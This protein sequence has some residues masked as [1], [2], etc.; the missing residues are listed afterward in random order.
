MSA[1]VE[2]LDSQESIAAIDRSGMLSV[3]GEMPAMMEKAERIAA[4]V[5]LPK[6]DQVSQVLVLGMGGSAISGDIAS[7]ILF[8]RIKVPLLVNRGYHIPEFV[9]PETLILALSYSG[10][11]EEV[12]NATREAERKQARIICVTSGGKLQ[13]MA[14]S[15]N[16]PLFQIPSGYQPRAALP[17]MLVPLLI[18][19]EKTGMIGDVSAE[20]KEARTLLQK[21]SAEYGPRKPQRNNAVKQLAK[22]LLNKTPI[23]FGSAYSTGAAA[24][25]IKDQF[26]ENSKVTAIVDYFPEL[27]HNQIASLSALKREE[28]EFAWIILRDEGDSERVKKVIEIVKSLIGQK[29][30][31]VNE[32]F[33]EGKS[34]LARILSLIIYGDYLSVYLALLRGVDPT[35]V[36]AIGRLKK[37]MQ[38]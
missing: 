24:L 33:S 23:I 35:P 38:R 37:E 9:G 30:G 7:D 15:K 10:D 14:A 6:P 20:I 12:L 28:N 31:G 36:E 5:S 29:L 11:T 21:L 32:L 2:I 18:G 26:N 8:K 17:F 4:A 34:A 25:R 16:Y 3:V 22:K 13:Q 19:L 27:N 1:E